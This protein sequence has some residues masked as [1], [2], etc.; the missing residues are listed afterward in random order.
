MNY[1]KES[2]LINIKYS[3]KSTLEVEINEKPLDYY[4]DRAFTSPIFKQITENLSGLFT[5]RIS[6]GGLGSQM[7]IIEKTLFKRCE[8]KFQS[9]LKIKYPQIDRNDERNV[10]PKK[11]GG[12]KSRARS[13]KSYR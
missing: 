7:E 12:R 11:Y 10:Y 6:G 3:P 5:L 1:R 9:V 4:T 13:Q 2:K 8:S